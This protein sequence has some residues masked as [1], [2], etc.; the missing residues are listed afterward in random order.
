MT[1]I[2]SSSLDFLLQHHDE[3]ASRK[4]RSSNV[5]EGNRPTTACGTSCAV[6][7]VSFSRHQGRAA[8]GL[9]EQTVREEPFFSGESRRGMGTSEQ[10]HLSVQRGWGSSRSPHRNRC[11]HDWHHS[12]SREALY[13]TCTLA[14]LPLN[15]PQQ[16]CQM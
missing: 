5:V 16:P 1:G 10:N 11:H 15:H 9:G 6:A 8:V 13:R 4:E 14:L 12:L 2:Q 3:S 7:A